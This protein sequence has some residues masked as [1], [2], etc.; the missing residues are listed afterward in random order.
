MSAPQFSVKR[1]FINGENDWHYQKT[2]AA[3]TTSD[4]QYIYGTKMFADDVKALN[5]IYCSGSYYGDGS[6]LT[7]ISGGSS[8]LQEV[9]T[10]GNTATGLDLVLTGGSYYGDGSQL[11]GIST[12]STLEQVLTNGNTATDLDI[13]LN[14]GSYY[15]DGSHLTGLPGTSQNLQQV[16]DVGN[17]V[18]DTDI[19]V[20]G[21]GHYFATNDPAGKATTVDS[22][23][24]V[25]NSLT[26][27]SEITA[28]QMKVQK[29]TNTYFVVN[30]D[31]GVF[32]KQT[33]PAPFPGNPNKTFDHALGDGNFSASEQ[34]SGNSLNFACGDSFSNSQIVLTSGGNTNIIEAGGFLT[35]QGSNNAT[36]YLTFLDSAANDSISKIQ[37]N[38]S[39]ACNPN[40]SSITATTFNGTATKLNVADQL[41]AGTYYPIFGG[42]ASGSS[43]CYVDS[44]SGP[45]TY[46]PSTGT[47]TTTTFVGAL[48]GNASSASQ[49]NFVDTNNNATYY[50]PFAAGVGVQTNNVAAIAGAPLTYNPGTGV[51]SATTFSGAF[52]GTITNATN[53]AN[54]TGITVASDSSNNTFY[55]VFVSSATGVQAPK[56]DND[57][58]PFSIN[59]STGTMAINGNTM[60]FAQHRI[61]IGNSAATGAAYQCSL[62]SNAGSAT[63]TGSNNICIGYQAGQS[64]NNA[65]SQYICIGNAAGQTNPGNGAIAIGYQAA[66]SG[67]DYSI[68]IGYAAGPTTLP[69]NS[70]LLNASGTNINPATAAAFYVNPVRNRSTTSGLNYLTYNTSTFEIGYSSQVTPASVVTTTG[71]G[72][73]NLATPLADLYLVDANVSPIRNCGL[74]NPSATLAGTQVIF[75]RIVN[76]TVTFNINTAGGG[77]VIYAF[78][79]PTTT[80]A[81][82]IGATQYNSILYCDGTYWYEISRM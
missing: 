22:N 19:I 76:N 77:S 51:L 52:S 71:T 74:P 16:L 35:K 39:L 56:I 11:T 69:A 44:S 4:D 6:H 26:G 15:G 81:L 48:T 8:T 40:Q 17:T 62:G 45:F 42:S 66:K 47:L 63:A 59:P 37:K 13:H 61:A 80:T 54:A 57:A 27:F 46:N 41:T 30:G 78:N 10:N 24:V 2:K 14:G 38:S 68:G 29:D 9:L 31:S 53:A 60:T 58:G 49:T 21:L 34:Y 23:H 65:S 36:H 50:V 55:P 3:V 70:I 28:S 72:Q 1:R 79:S 32:F 18:V 75:R 20:T 12:S 82:V 7:G 64:V 5:N 43:F 25:V 33:I 67:G 73:Q